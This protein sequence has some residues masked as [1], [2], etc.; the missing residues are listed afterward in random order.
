MWSISNMAN[1]IENGIKKRS[2]QEQHENYISLNEMQD[3]GTASGSGSSSSIRR[4]TNNKGEFSQHQ[5]NSDGSSNSSGS[6]S[7]SRRE[8]EEEINII[9]TTDLRNTMINGTMMKKQ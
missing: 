7:S 5:Y 2:E 3:G 8:E 1:T 4:N 9:D 6:G